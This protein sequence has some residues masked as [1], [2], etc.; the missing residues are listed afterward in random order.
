MDYISVEQAAEKWDITRR[1][2][3]LLCAKGKIDDVVKISNVWMIPSDAAKP[4]DGRRKDSK[5]GVFAIGIPFF[6]CRFNLLGY[7]NTPE[8]RAGRPAQTEPLTTRETVDGLP[9]GRG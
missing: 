2:V 9:Y 8:T 7:A 3:Q 1:H 4:P 6:R 5:T